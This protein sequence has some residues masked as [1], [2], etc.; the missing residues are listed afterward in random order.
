MRHSAF[1]SEILTPR[2]SSVGQEEAEVTSLILSFLP[3][4]GQL[5][6]KIKLK[7]KIKKNL[8]CYAY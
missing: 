5:L 8:K 7:L 2:G 6:T 1:E 3:H 4:W